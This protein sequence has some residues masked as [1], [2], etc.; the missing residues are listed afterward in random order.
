MPFLTRGGHGKWRCRYRPAGWPPGPPVC[1]ALAPAGRT[2]AR[3]RR[4]PA[5]RLCGPVP[6]HLPSSVPSVSAPPSPLHHNSPTP[7]LYHPHLCLH[8]FHSSPHL[9]LRIPI[10]GLLSPSCLGPLT[11]S[12]SV[13]SSSLP[14]SPFRFS[15]SSP[16]PSLPLI[17]S[18]S[19]L[20]PPLPHHRLPTAG[21]ASLYPLFSYLCPPPTSHLCP[22]YHL[23]LRRVPSLPLP[24]LHI[25]LY[26]TS[27]SPATVPSLSCLSPITVLPPP[28]KQS[29]R[30]TVSLF[31]QPH[32]L[33]LWFLLSTP[34]HFC[35]ITSGVSPLSLYTDYHLLSQRPLP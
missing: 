2:P 30:S 21:P 31:S 3:E 20:P 27:V 28:P 8:H 26:F 14:S 13:L 12:P 22:I 34:L 15:C 11:T 9:Y 19:G 18:P 10:S 4:G 23:W 24:P 7:S 6:P 25:C 17:I 29:T 5:P 35:P 32:S 16:P 1:A 33:N